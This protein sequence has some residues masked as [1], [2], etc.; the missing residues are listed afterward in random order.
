MKFKCLSLEGGR[1]PTATQ[2]CLAVTRAGR[3][4]FNAATVARPVATLH[5]PALDDD[6]AAG[7]GS[8]FTNL[9]EHVSAGVGQER[10]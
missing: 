7:E 10:A 1:Q 4:T 9:R 5:G 2:S 3:F 8:F 6:F